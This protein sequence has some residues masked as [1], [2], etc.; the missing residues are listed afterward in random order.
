MNSIVGDFKS[1]DTIKYTVFK[2]GEYIDFDIKI[3]EQ[4]KK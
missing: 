3:T 1:G 4:E 2:N